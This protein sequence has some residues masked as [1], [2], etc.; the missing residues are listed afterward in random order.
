MYATAKKTGTLKLNP[1]TDVL[2]FQNKLKLFFADMINNLLRICK[3]ESA[4]DWHN[5]LYIVHVYESVYILC[6]WL[7]R[8][9]FAL[10]DGNPG[11]KSDQ[12]SL[13]EI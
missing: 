8:Q 3:V 10:S 13:S 7:T 11:T 6:A 4:R 5:F 2:L 12:V 9:H 1:A